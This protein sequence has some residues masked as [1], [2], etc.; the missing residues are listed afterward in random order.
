MTT[1]SSAGGNAPKDGAAAFRGVSPLVLDAKGRLAI[2]AKHRDTLRDGG[3]GLVITAD[4]SR[5]LLLYPRQI[6]EPIQAQLMSF[7]S[8]EDR[9]RSWQRLLVGYADDVDIDAS[10]RILVPPMLREYARIDRDVVLVGQGHR[11]E[12]WDQNAW[13]AQ[14]ERA[15][16][17]PAN[18]LPPELGGFAL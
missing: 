2:P 5:C 3:A 18:G 11:F 9:I 13:H 8:F 1:G 6:W 14:T 15:A 16:E 12:I 7:S 4:P 17:F 10:G